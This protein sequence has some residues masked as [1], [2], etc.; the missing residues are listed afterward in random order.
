M[1]RSGLGFPSLRHTR[2]PSGTAGLL[3]LWLHQHRGGERGVDVAAG[4]ARLGVE[5]GAGGIGE[6]APHRRTERVG[7]GALRVGVGGQQA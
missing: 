3:Q 6:P 2:G 1:S 4:A 5:C 7:V